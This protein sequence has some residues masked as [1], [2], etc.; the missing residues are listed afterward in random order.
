MNGL[1]YFLGECVLVSAPN[2]AGKQFIN[3]LRERGVGYY[4]IVNSHSG[5]KR[6][7][8]IGV[9]KIISVD[10]SDGNKWDDAP[11]LPI[12]KV[13]LFEDSFTL[14]CRLIQLCSNWRLESIY[15]IT[16]RKYNK[17]TY[18]ALGATHIFFINKCDVSFLVN[19]ID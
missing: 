4:A 2:E 12:R 7:E 1:R 16:R 9:K 6:M 15:V 5:K 11:H 19:D 3:E 8:A 17:Q 14:T 18:R 13:F 10:T